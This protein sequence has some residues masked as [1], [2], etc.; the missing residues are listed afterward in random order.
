[1]WLLNNV[2]ETQEIIGRLARFTCDED[3]WGRDYDG[4]W[5]NIDDR[6][7]YGWNPIMDWNHWRQVE[8]CL[9]RYPES[10]GNLFYKFKEK[11]LERRNN[12]KYAQGGITAYIEADL[13]TRCQILVDLL[14]EMEDTGT[15]R[16]TT[17]GKEGATEVYTDGVFVCPSCEIEN[18]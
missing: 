2:M 1:M 7:F 5:V 15:A 18:L 6:H 11:L 16:C 4:Y 12:P 9:R 13:L 8:Q 3:Y 10:E 14:E 17:C